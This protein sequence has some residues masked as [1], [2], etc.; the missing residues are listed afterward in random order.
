M[1]FIKA[2]ICNL[3]QTSAPYTITHYGFL[4]TN[5]LRK[6]VTEHLGNLVTS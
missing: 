1:G 6:Y 2:L 4:L 5:I 3:D